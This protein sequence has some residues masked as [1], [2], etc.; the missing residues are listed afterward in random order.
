MTDFLPPP[1]TAYEDLE[2]PR[3]VID[4]AAMEHTSRPSTASSAAGPPGCG[5]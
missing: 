5:A 4:L 3:L 1:G 2:T